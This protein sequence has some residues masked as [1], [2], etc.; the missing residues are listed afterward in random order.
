VLRNEVIVIAAR[1]GARMVTRAYDIRDIMLPLRDFVGPVMELVPP[2]GAN[3]GVLIIFPSEDPKSPI[4][5]EMVVDLVKTSISD[6]AWEGDAS[7]N[8][9]GGLLVVTQT[10]AV[11]DEIRRLLDRLRQYK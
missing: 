7:V 3:M 1:A 5:E 11:Q 6:A 4:T 9:V 8:Q 2:G 10:A